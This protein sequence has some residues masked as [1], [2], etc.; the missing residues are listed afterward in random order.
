MD[1]C[2]HLSNYLSIEVININ[3]HFFLERINSN[4]M[5]EG[6]F[7]YHKYMIKSAQYGEL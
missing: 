2:S 5:S 4:K 3:I 7:R 6:A 1:I